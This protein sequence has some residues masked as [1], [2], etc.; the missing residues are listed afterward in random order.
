[1][2]QTKEYQGYSNYETWNY[3]LHVDNNQEQLEHVLA[4][5]KE[6]KETSETPSYDLKEALKLELEENMPDLTVDVYSDL[7][8]GAM[9]SIN[10]YEVAK[11]YLGR[12]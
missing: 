11:D 3:C 8:N 1:M 10:W 12:V 5:A 6:I 2:T 9:E 4:L 7:L